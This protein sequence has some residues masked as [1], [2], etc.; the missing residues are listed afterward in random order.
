MQYES[1]NVYFRID[2]WDRNLA[3]SDIPVGFFWVAE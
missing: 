2:S 3:Y 1:V